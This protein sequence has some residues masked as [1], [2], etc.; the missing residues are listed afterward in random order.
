VVRMRIL[1]GAVSRVFRLH[2]LPDFCPT[3]LFDI[4]AVSGDGSDKKVSALFVT[5]DPERDTP[6]VLKTYLETSIPASS[7]DC[8]NSK[9]EA[10]QGL[11]VYA[12]KVPGENPSMTIRS[13]IPVSS[14]SWTSAVNS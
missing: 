6:D 7:A 11:R 4:S 1:L 3:A 8:D 5:V 2:A 14:I 10:S 13:I 9:I 12:K